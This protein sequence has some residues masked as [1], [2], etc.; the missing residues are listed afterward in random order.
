M[1]R[2]RRTSVKGVGDSSFGVMLLTIVMVALGSVPHRVLAHGRVEPIGDNARISAGWFHTCEVKGTRDVVC[3]GRN[4]A[5]QAPML[6]P[7]PF[8]QISS[9]ASHTCGVKTTGEVAC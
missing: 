8:V 9:G 4:T 3:W 1:E 7:G 6:V 5:D 2:R